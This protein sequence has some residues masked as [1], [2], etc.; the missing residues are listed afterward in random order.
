MTI[1]ASTAEDRGRT[2]PLPAQAERTAALGLCLGI[3]VEILFYGHPLGISVLIWA[4][5]CVAALLLAARSYGA[6]AARS[7]VWLAA[8]ILFFAA[9][10]FLRLEGLSV[11]LSL[12]ATVGLLLLWVRTFRVGDL[13]AFGWTDFALT[14]LLVPLEGWIA[15]WPVLGTLQ[16]R[17]LS[18]RQGRAQAMAILRGVLLA[19][20]ILV[21]L[22]AL[23]SGADIIFADRVEEALRWLDLER[24]TEWIGRGTVIL[25]SGL[26]SLGCLVQALR[27]LGSRRLAGEAEPLVRP[28]L[29]FP[30]ATVV[31]S[32]VN[33]VFGLFV[34]IQFTYLFG[35]AANITA[36][37]YTYAQYARRGFGE[38]VAVSIISLGLIMALGTWAR[39]D[40]RRHSRWFNGL[41]GLLVAQ[42]GV[43]L[44]SALQRLLLYENAY[45]F[46]RLRTYTH[47]AILW[48]AGLFL[49]FLVL[50]LLGRLRRF[51]LVAAAAALGFTA[52]LNLLN[53]DRF[54]VARN[55]ARLAESGELDLSYLLQLSEDAVPALVVLGR[56][57]P[58]EVREALAPELTCWFAQSEL[59]Q[60]RLAVGTACLAFAPRAALLGMADQ[61]AGHQVWRDRENG[62]M[63]EVAGEGKPCLRQMLCTDGGLT[64]RLTDQPHKSQTGLCGPVSLLA[65][66]RPVF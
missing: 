51:V 53:V 27:P 59:R 9:M 38:L 4:T 45:G 46:T 60:Y 29:G 33:L 3:A 62:W 10:P 22:I 65:A 8:P 15:P 25:L 13:F 61:M 55:A 43:I 41:S 24:I 11:L 18:N 21:L 20:P 28:F 30:E 6:S 1:N 57:A 14:W 54:I 66:R 64:W 2:N 36:A 19:F 52:T 47:V 34:A 32:G 48:M 26:F 63:V 56:T 50:L 17:M 7:S 5:L 31:L 49:A 39:R 40:T 44:A 35:G 23:L 58:A 16:Q 42:M 37:G 12:A